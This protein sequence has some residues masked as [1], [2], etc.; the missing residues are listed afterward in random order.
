MRRLLCALI[1]ELHRGRA[2]QF[3]RITQGGDIQRVD[4]DGIQTNI[5]SVFENVH[6]RRHTCLPQREAK[7][8]PNEPYTGDRDRLHAVRPPVRPQWR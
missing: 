6:L 7:R 5:R 3:L 2:L 1:D 4:T 8:A